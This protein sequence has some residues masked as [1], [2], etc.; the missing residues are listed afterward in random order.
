MKLRYLFKSLASALVLNALA[1]FLGACSANDNPSGGDIPIPVPSAETNVTF[2]LKDSN[3]SS[4]IAAVKAWMLIGNMTY[5]VLPDEASG[6]IQVSFPGISNGHVGLSAVTAEGR[7]WLAN[8]SGMTFK[9]GN[10]YDQIVEM[11]EDEGVQL[12][13]GGPKFASVNVGAASPADYGLFFAWGSTEDNTS[14]GKTYSWANTPYYTGDGTTHSWSK[15]TTG[16]E[17]LDPADDAASAN[18]GGEWRTPT[19][20]EYQALTDG[21]NVIATWTEDYN[22]TGVSGL[23]FTGAK[24]G[25]RDKSIFLVAGGVNM[26]NEVKGDRQG[27]GYWSATLAAADTVRSM[28]FRPQGASVYHHLRYFGCSIRPVKG[29]VAPVVVPEDLSDVRL[30]DLGLPSGTKWASRDIGA[31]GE[32]KPG[33]FFAFGELEGYDYVTH[34]QRN[35]FW[36]T[37]RWN[38]GGETGDGINK[39]YAGDGKTE[40]DPE[41]DAAVMLWGGNWRMPT[42]AEVQE[43]ID[44]CTSELTTI[45]G[46]TVR[47]FTSKT[48][49]ETVLFPV[50]GDIAKD[51]VKARNERGYYWSKTLNEED[52]SQ[53]MVLFLGP[54]AVACFPAARFGG[55]PIR[56]VQ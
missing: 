2:T 24:E 28:N 26:N 11:T 25:F 34:T 22:G 38:D 40:L 44:G 12:W 20:E 5:I 53:G 9:N 37:Y 47:L 31:E 39:Y 42:A 49:G 14:L 23:I 29:K 19:V 45:D 21:N 41:D 46:E 30:I 36:N 18:W 54:N 43:L 56:P 51:E 32:G 8:L 1:S 48:N 13:E 16:G 17:T 55:R 33:L 35:F 4:E 7:V 6:K 27:G 52:V 15:Y 50:S 10:A 3:G